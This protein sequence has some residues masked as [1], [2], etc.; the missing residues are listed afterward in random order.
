MTR[1]VKHPRFDGYVC[2]VKDCAR[3][4]FKHGLC[5]KHWQE[6]PLA[7]R[8]GIMA[9]A[10]HAAHRAAK[11]HDGYLAKWAANYPAGVAAGRHSYAATVKAA[12]DALSAR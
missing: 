2:L 5:R 7:E 11:R 9:D 10:V 12:S 3:V 4:D 6:V 8:M 1:R